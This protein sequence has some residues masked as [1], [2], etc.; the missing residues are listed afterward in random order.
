MVVACGGGCQSRVFF[1]MECQLRNSDASSTGY[2]DILKTSCCLV[3]TVGWWA[4]CCNVGRPLPNKREEGRRKWSVRDS[5]AF[6]LLNTAFCRLPYT[7]KASIFCMNSLI[8]LIN[9]N[10]FFWRWEMCFNLRLGGRGRW[11]ECKGRTKGRWSLKRRRAW[12][13]DRRLWKAWQSTGNTQWPW[14]V[15]HD[16]RGR[17]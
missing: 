11:G 2:L 12:G 7:L 13:R 15:E 6:L 9:L 4:G 8:S 10:A 16:K 3:K 17:W 14:V 5:C 1:H